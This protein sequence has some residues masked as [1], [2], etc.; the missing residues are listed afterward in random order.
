M[1][2]DA[3]SKNDNGQ[4]HE[5]MVFMREH[6]NVLHVKAERLGSND[7]LYTYYLK[8]HAEDPT[9]GKVPDYRVKASRTKPSSSDK[10]SL[11]RRR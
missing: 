8:I 3:L 4:A 7:Y 5:L 1:I 2:E 9:I 11:L 10:K 6:F